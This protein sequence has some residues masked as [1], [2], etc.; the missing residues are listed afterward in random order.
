M[1]G[2]CDQNEVEDEE[3]SSGNALKLRLADEILSLGGC[4]QIENI[5]D[6]RMSSSHQRFGKNLKDGTSR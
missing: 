6:K 4:E 5:S 1:L 3:F 2:G